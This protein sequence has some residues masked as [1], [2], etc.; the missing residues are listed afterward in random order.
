V[1]SL[2]HRRMPVSSACS[3]RLTL[4]HYAL[5]ATVASTPVAACCTQLEPRSFRDVTIVQVREHFTGAPQWDE[6]GLLQI[7]PQRLHVRP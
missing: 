3:K 6:L 5:C 2:P 7:H 4:S 1:C